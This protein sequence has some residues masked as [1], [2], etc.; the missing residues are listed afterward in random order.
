MAYFSNGSAACGFESQCA[1][2]RFGRVSFGK[3]QCPIAMAQIMFNY[4]AVNNKVATK[5][6]DSLIK[7]DGTCEMY[8][9]FEIEFEPQIDFPIEILR[10]LESE[11][12]K[13]QIVKTT[14]LR[15]ILRDIKEHLNQK[16]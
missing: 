7:N 6:L 9:A 10:D 13:P 1:K 16:L 8:K 12:E 5:I 14:K 2:C 15:E 11:L 4:D 3:K